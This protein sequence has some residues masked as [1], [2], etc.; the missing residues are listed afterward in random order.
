MNKFTC[1]IFV[2]C[3]CNPHRKSNTHHIIYW[4][5]SAIVYGWN[6]VYGRD[7][8]IPMGRPDF[9]KNPNTKTVG[10]MIWPMIALWSTGKVVVM[11]SGLCVLKWIL[12][13]RNRG[14]Y[15]SELIKK[16]WYC[17]R[18][19]HGDGINEYPSQKNIVDVVCLSC[20][21]YNIYF[22]IFVTKEPDYNI[23]MISNFSGLNV[24]E[25]QKEYIRMLNGEVLKCN[26]PEVVSYN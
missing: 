24:T 18:G 4:G 10:I 6:I 21:W 7:N 2:F 1:P 14:V 17:H 11:D 20:E 22:N 26:C 23:M 16:R 8:P 13:V 25:V 5:E 3:P 19:F 15:G 9:E 12:E